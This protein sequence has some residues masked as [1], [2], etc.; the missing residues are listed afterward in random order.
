MGDYFQSDKLI[1][2]LIID[3]HVNEGQRMWTLSKL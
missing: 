2:E 3:K 1:M